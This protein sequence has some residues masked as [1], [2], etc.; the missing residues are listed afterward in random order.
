[1]DVID[2]SVECK[3]EINETVLVLVKIIMLL[4]LVLFTEQITKFIYSIY[5]DELVSS[6]HFELICNI[7]L[8][9]CQLVVKVSPVLKDKPKDQAVRSIDFQS[10]HSKLHNH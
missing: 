7:W 6:V 10:L 5:I 3:N 8:F 2:R 1:V 4:P 9:L